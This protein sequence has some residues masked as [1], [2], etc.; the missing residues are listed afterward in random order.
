MYLI[1]NKNLNI[2]RETSFSYEHGWV[3]VLVMSKISFVTVH[4]FR[5]FTKLFIHR[6]TYDRPDVFRF[7]RSISS[8]V[9]VLEALIV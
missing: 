3:L 4:W 8:E 2:S 6:L 9:L 5:F 7:Q 1:L